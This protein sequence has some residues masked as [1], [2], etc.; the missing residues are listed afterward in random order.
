[1]FYLGF[2]FFSCK[3]KLKRTSLC[4][5]FFSSLI[6]PSIENHHCFLRFARFCWQS[7]LCLFFFL[8]FFFVLQQGD[9]LQRVNGYAFLF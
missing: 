3:R 2:L 8:I 7:F 6:L 4:V 5:F 9:K 1:M